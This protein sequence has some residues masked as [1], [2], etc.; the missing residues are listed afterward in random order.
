MLPCRVVRFQW[1]FVAIYD[2]NAPILRDY[3][4]IAKVSY[5]EREMDSAHRHHG[6]SHQ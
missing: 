3:C 2:A 4:S 5:N 1:T 6:A